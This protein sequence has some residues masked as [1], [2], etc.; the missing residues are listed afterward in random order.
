MA[1]R[2]GVSLSC[3]AGW[4]KRRQAPSSGSLTIEV[5]R[6]LY[7]VTGRTVDELWPPPKRSVTLPDTP[8]LSKVHA[9]RLTQL[10]LECAERNTLPSP[11]DAVALVDDCDV[12]HAALATLTKK[13]RTVIVH[14]FGLN[15]SPAETLRQIGR[16]IGRT[17][18]AVRQIEDK[19]LARLRHY[20]EHPGSRALAH[21]R[22]NRRR[23]KKFVQENGGG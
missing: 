13:Q 19:A 23:Q 3:V 2:I 7:A 8:H 20:F 12:L 5:Q 11:E 1:Q 10:A 15:G 17:A 16:R 4:I 21:R 6:E 22:V 18:E 14:H 9:A